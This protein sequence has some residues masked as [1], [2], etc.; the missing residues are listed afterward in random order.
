M[1]VYLGRFSPFHLGHKMV[2]DIMIN[3]YVIDNCLVIIGSSNITDERTPFSYQTRFEMVKS[4][5]PDIAALALPD[6]YS[7]DIWLDNIQKIEKEMGENFIFVGGSKKD[8]SILSQIFKTEVIVD[9]DIQGRGIT[10][11]EVRKNIRLGNRK[12][13]KKLVPPE[14][15]S[16]LY[17]SVVG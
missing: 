11:T 14:I 2:V 4:V 17:S 8:L 7:D 1:Y 9:R 6:V 16:R 5:F 15:Y 3:R 12:K 10:A 13:I